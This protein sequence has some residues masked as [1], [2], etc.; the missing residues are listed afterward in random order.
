MHGC[1]RMNGC[2]E[3]SNM[4]VEIVWHTDTTDTCS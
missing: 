4:M 1:S 3:F 2:N